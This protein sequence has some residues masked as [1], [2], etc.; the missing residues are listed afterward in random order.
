VADYTNAPWKNPASYQCVG[1]MRQQEQASTNNCGT[2]FVDNPCPGIQVCD[3]SGANYCKT[4]VGTCL[5]TE[6]NDTLTQQICDGTTTNVA[7]GTVWSVATNCD[8][9]VKCQYECKVGYQWN[10]ADAC[11]PMFT[12]YSCIGSNT[13]PSG[14]GRV[15][16]WSAVSNC[17]SYLF[18][19][20]TIYT[21]GNTVCLGAGDTA[22]TAIVT[23]F[24]L[25]EKAIKT[26]VNPCPNNEP[27]W[28]FC[29]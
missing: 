21:F 3:A 27:L 23:S 4:P 29:N 6:P 9:S 13:C 5:G 22:P 16:T 26:G 1:T 12:K 18:N 14:V 7:S 19:L 28:Y 17:Y 24:Y 2:Q 20:S 25:A 10:G 11:V 8:S 15:G